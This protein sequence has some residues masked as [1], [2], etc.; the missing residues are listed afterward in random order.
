MTYTNQY[1]SSRFVC[2]FRAKYA[3]DWTTC[4]SRPRVQAVLLLMLATLASSRAIA[5]VGAAQI[6]GAIAD[7]VGAPVP[8][9]TVTVTSLAT[10]QLRT[11]LTTADGIYA[12]PS[13]PPVG[14]GW[15][16]CCPDRSRP[17]RGHS[18]RHRRTRRPRRDPR[19]RRPSREDGQRDRQ[20]PS[21][22]AHRNPAASGQVVPQRPRSPRFAPRRPQ[23]SSP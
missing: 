8:G 10:S 13:L 19:R 14:I 22:A 17:T 20:K 18:C 15:T 16:W 23:S 3:C 21:D 6:T 2:R 4:V 5:Q 11:V 7:P 9:A 12:V 1:D